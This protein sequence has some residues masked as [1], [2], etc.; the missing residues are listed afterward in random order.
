MTV[1]LTPR[2]VG[3]SSVN[4]S[5]GL[6]GPEG[7]QPALGGRGTGGHLLLLAIGRL[8]DKAHVDLLHVR[9]G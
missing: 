4:G 3:D 2:A 7:Q 5:L 1:R 6:K 8:R 9:A